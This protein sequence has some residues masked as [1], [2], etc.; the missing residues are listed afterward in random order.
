MSTK[1]ATLI[2]S[3]LLSASVSFTTHVQANPFSGLIDTVTDSIK[4]NSIGSKPA[5][6]AAASGKKGEVLLNTCLSNFK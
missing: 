4:G 6:P 2:S 1:K 5:Q 3:V